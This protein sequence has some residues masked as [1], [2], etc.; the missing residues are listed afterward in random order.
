VRDAGAAGV[1]IMGS[2]MRATNPAQVV[3]D[4]LSR[5]EPSSA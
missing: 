4:M 1:A 2:V 5:L 3:S